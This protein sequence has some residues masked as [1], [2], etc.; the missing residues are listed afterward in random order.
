V[1]LELVVCS[2]GF[3]LAA[4]LGEV[5]GSTLTTLVRNLSVDEHYF[6]AINSEVKS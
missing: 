4:S 2:E 3:N 1:S 5:P 6:A